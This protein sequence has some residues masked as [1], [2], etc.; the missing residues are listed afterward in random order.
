MARLPKEMWP[1][2]ILRYP[3]WVRIVRIGSAVTLMGAAVAS[4]I[5]AWI[6][7]VRPLVQYVKT[8]TASSTAW[9]TALW[10]GLSVQAWHPFLGAHA[11]LVLVA[12]FVPF[13]STILPELALT[14]EG[15][16]VRDLRGWSLVPWDTIRA[17]RIASFETTERRLV[18]VQGRWARVALW[19]RLLSLCLG[20]GTAPGV[21]I[22]SSIHGFRPLM[23]RL[24]QEIKEASPDTVFDDEFLSPTASLLVEPTPTLAALAEQA[25]GEG[26]PLGVSAQVMLAVPGGLVVTQLLLIVLQ[27]GLWWKPLAILGLCQF[28]WLIG[29]LYLYALAELYPSQ[30]ELRQAALLYPLPQLPRALLA[31]LMA[32]FVASGFTFVAGVIGLGAVLWA[33]MLTALLVQQMYRLPSILPA[34]VGGALQALFQFLVLA[35]ALT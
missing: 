18:I 30:I 29:T 9:G 12:A 10:Q 35:I 23:V 2:Y 15:L 7:F 28:E 5:L 22:E 34:M 3:R 13:L 1:T 27:G 19:P 31:V 25:R 33:V 20:A 24:Y 14:D 4:W 16:A 26:W 6:G 8:L 11:G 21:L 17:M 32:A